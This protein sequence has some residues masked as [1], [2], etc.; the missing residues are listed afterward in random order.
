VA[1]DI[2]FRAKLWD[3]TAARDWLEPRLGLVDVIICGV[4]DAATVLGL[5][6]EPAQVVRHLA[7]AG[8]ADTAVL[9][10]GDQGALAW[11]RGEELSVA[12][13]P[14]AVVDRLGAGDAFTAG[15]LD[16]L[17]DGSLHAGLQ[18]GVTLAAAA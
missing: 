11:E 7:A 9:T 8:R 15:L 2:N 4:Q 13:V 3:P 5:S 17:L 10:L 16:G 18:R 6:G 14:A 12:S 1:F